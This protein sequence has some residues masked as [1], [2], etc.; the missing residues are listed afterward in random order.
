[1]KKITLLLIAMA[2][3]AGN[4]QHNSNLPETSKGPNIPY[5]KGYLVE[6]INNDLYW[7]TDGLYNA[8]FLVYDQGV[9]MVDA[10]PT[11]GENLL[12][13]IKDVTN[14]PVTHLVYT[15][16]HT[17]HIGAAAL[18]PKDIEIIAQEETKKILEARNDDRRPVPTLTFE[19]NYELKIGGQHL[20]LDYHGKNHMD[21]NIFVYAPKQKVLMLV[22]IIFPGWVP[23]KN[24]G[25]AEDVPA[26]MKAHDIALD[27]DFETFVAGHVTRLGNREDVEVSKAFVTDLKNTC[28]QAFGKVDF[29]ESAQETGF[30]DK[31]MM[32]NTYFEKVVDVA[33]KEMHGKWMGKLGGLDTY[34]RDDVWKMCESLSVDF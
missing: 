30:E 7:V 21:G 10:P 2:M 17:D 27:Y 8:I 11:I 23:F 33:T 5:D 31:W 14:K 16:S 6:E 24:L 28:Q 20:Q 15:H 9:V 12:A 13:A 26:Y 29:M 22:D 3:I 4:A 1:M 19:K 25:I 32:Y 18:F 34:L